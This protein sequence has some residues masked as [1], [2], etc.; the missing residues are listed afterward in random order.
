MAADA[1]TAGGP[2]AALGVGC[3]RGSEQSREPGRR[4]GLWPLLRKHV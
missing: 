4:K 2:G 1:L 3:G